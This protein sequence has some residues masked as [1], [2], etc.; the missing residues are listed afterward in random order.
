[1]TTML[2][3]LLLPLLDGI[4][5]FDAFENQDAAFPFQIL[6]QLFSTDFIICCTYYT[7]HALERKKKN[8]VFKFISINL[9]AYNSIAIGLL[10]FVPIVCTS[11]NN[12]NITWIIVIYKTE[13]YYC[14]DLL[15]YVFVLKFCCEIVLNRVYP[16]Q[17]HRFLFS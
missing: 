16:S 10:F 12:W 9:A 5:P 13:I 3:F 1:M 17:E 4:I 15:Y 11:Y 7:C 14:V 8:S 2:C 6:H